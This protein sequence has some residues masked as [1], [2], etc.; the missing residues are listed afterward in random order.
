MAPVDYLAEGRLD[1]AVAS[2]LVFAVSSYRRFWGIASRRPG[3][4]AIGAHF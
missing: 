2:L 3:T 4:L 1:A